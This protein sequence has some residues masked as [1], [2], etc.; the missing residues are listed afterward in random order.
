MSASRLP[1]THTRS[2]TCCCVSC[3]SGSTGGRMRWFSSSTSTSTLDSLLAAV[4]RPK[5]TNDGNSNEASSS[6]SRVKEEE[7]GME[8]GT[9]VAIPSLCSGCGAPFQTNFEYKA[10]YVTMATLQHYVRARANWQ[11]QQHDAIKEHEE[12]LHEKKLQAEATARISSTP[13]ELLRAQA[14]SANATTTTT[15]NDNGATSATT[16]S[17]NDT[18]GTLDEDGDNTLASPIDLNADLSL[19]LMEGKINHDQVQWTLPRRK[20]RYLAKALAEGRPYAGIP[21]SGWTTMAQK[22][23]LAVPL[24]TPDLLEPSGSIS[25]A[26]ALASSGN[27]PKLTKKQLA[28]ARIASDFGGQLVYRE[29]RAPKCARCHQ[30]THYG[31]TKGMIESVKADDFRH[32]L[33]ERFLQR[34][35]KSCVILKMVDMFDFDGS[36]IHNFK[37]TSFHFC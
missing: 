13:I 27:Q 14:A 28:L 19:D 3:A 25:D 18:N 7:T 20:W 11:L 12:R 34:G 17:N 5:P 35:G 15:T 9:R 29:P 37:V 16:S 4:N 8:D 10:G 32:L 21:P 31:H 1:N 6:L 2:T 23:G 22:M 30:L 24:I 26:V 33:R 36:V